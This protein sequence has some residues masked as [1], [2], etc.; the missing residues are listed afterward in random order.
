MFC[1][2]WMTLPSESVFSAAAFQQYVPSYVTSARVQSRNGK[3]LVGTLNVPRIWWAKS[4]VRPPFLML[5]QIES[6]RALGSIRMPFGRS[7]YSLGSSTTAEFV[8]L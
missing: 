6:R 5:L 4:F 1:P 3:L 7:T 8:A 2:F